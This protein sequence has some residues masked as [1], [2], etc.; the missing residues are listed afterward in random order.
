MSRKPTYEELA[1]WYEH[2]RAFHETPLGR[3]FLIAQNEAMKAQTKSERLDQL[4]IDWGQRQ[5][6]SFDLSEFYRQF[7]KVQGP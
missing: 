6:K 4:M 3:A 7:E 2:V 5:T 1:A